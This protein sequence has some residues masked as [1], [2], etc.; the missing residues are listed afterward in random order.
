MARKHISLAG[1]AVIEE[2]RASVNCLLMAAL[3]EKSNT[4]VG[5]TKRVD[6]CDA[7]AH[8]AILDVA[9]WCHMGSKKTVVSCWSCCS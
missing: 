9:K 5:G 2:R 4:A 1:Q 7:M 3:K 6:N 8:R